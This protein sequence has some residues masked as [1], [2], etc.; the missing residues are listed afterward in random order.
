MASAPAYLPTGQAS[1]AKVLWQGSCGCLGQSSVSCREAVLHSTRSSAA[2]MH[3][4]LG[5]SVEVGWHPSLY[6]SPKGGSCDGQRCMAGLQSEARAGRG[7]RL[8][9]P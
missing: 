7:V 2:V 1:H 6:P 8:P 9:C 4:V 3:I 5:A